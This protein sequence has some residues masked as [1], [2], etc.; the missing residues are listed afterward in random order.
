MQEEDFI[1]INTFFIVYLVALEL[2]LE[3]MIKI[4][5]LNVFGM[6]KWHNFLQAPIVLL[7][8]IHCKTQN[9]EYLLVTSTFAWVNE[10]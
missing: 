3:D 1:G 6:D 8:I 9:T 10:Y 5:V 7:H 2:S 4:Q